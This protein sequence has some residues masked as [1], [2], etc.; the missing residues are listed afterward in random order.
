MARTDLDNRNVADWL[1]ERIR[2]G[3]LVPGERLVEADLVRA[4][5]ASRAKVREALKQL[6]T[7][8]L[9][10]LEEF[11]G[12]S[13][14]RHSLEEIRQIYQARMVLEG[15]AAAEFTRRA[16]A[17]QR[18]R[19]QAMQS[20]LDE[21]AD[22]GQHDTFA[23]LNADWHRLLIEGA[24][25]TMVTQFLERLTVPIYRLL[26]SNFYSR[27]RIVLANADHQ[28]VTMAIL[29]RQPEAAEAAMRAHISRGMAALAELDASFDA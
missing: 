2:K 6:G 25:N 24:G 9:V 13:V 1:R 11:R 29:A 17:S 3:L 7:E 18:S 23:R 12:A 10:T 4:T 16:D 20:A 19:L 5:G 28:V 22:A 27:Q 21:C 15:L 8:G 26:F 14:K